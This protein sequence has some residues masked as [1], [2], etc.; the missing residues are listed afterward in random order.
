MGVGWG[1]KAVSLKIGPPVFEEETLTWG[2]GTDRAQRAS[3]LGEQSVEFGR[4][5]AARV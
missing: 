5:E 4:A 3:E 1:N 2:Q